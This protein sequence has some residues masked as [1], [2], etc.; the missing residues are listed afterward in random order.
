MARLH[1]GYNL[2][3]FLDSRLVHRDELVVAFGQGFLQA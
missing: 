3:A 1:I 2:H